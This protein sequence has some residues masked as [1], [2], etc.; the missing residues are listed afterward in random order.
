MLLMTAAPLLALQGVALASLLAGA[1]DH[2]PTVATIAASLVLLRVALT[3]ATATAEK[4]PGGALLCLLSLLGTAALAATIAPGLRTEVP[5]VWP[6]LAVALGMGATL[7][8]ATRGATRL[9]VQWFVPAFRHDFLF[10]QLLLKRE[11]ET[12]AALVATG[13][14][15]EVLLRRAGGELRRALA[16]I[17]RKFGEAVQKDAAP[18]PQQQPGQP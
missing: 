8:L 15:D 11:A 7:E 3:V 18:R 6:P 5:S 2:A 13:L 12:A 9:A 10:D 1:F 17:E 16:N 4:A 14:Q